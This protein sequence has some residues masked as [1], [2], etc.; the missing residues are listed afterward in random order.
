MSDYHQYR[1]SGRRYESSGGRD[2]DEIPREDSPPNSRLF[3]IGGKNVTEEE[4]REAFGKYG[5]IEWLDIKKHRETGVAKGITYVKFT[6]T[7][8][9]AAAL[10]ELNGKVLGSDP[11]PL[12]I[13]IASSRGEGGG[14]GRGAAEEDDVKGTR[15]FLVVPKTMT[16]E[17]LRDVFS[18]YGPIEHITLV[19]DK[20]TGNPRGLAYV[21][22]YRFSNAARA[23]EKGDSSYRPKFAEPKPLAHTPAALADA[24]MRSSSS[25]SGRGMSFGGSGGGGGGGSGHGMSSSY[26]YG[27]G[28]GGYS[29][30]MGGGGGG[31]MGSGGGDMMPQQQ[32][33]NMSAVFGI[34]TQ[35]NSSVPNPTGS[36]RLR[37]LFNPN[38][39]KDMFWALFNIVPGLEH[40]E[41]I[42]MTPEGAWGGVIYNNPRSAAWAVERIH[43]F[44]YPAGRKLSVNFDDMGAPCG[45]GG[46]FNMANGMPGMGGQIGST[47]GGFGDIP[48]ANKSMPSDIQSLV[49]S[50]Q[51]ATEALKQSGYGSIVGAGGGVISASS[52]G[53]GFSS[54]GFGGGG[55]VS[56]ADAQAVCSAKLPSRQPIVP[57]S[58]GTEERLFFVF[59]DAR[60]APPPGI[61]TDVFCRFGN[62]IDAYCLRGKKCGYARYAS[63]E[64]AAEALAVLNA[65]TLVG[66]RLKVVEADEEKSGKRPRLD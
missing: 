63:K 66:S 64:S 24:A 6:K 40:C 43:G 45:G 33:N 59:K 32:Q 41:L 4:Y 15:L 25:S 37:V 21:R 18:E 57:I 44:E 20:G 26:G 22:F 53:G 52:P 60:E 8:E 29:S 46:A 50:I 14:G 39:S 28:G 16:E 11:R 7:S 19:R 62:L 31:Y 56:E 58:A 5:E 38:M 3:I 48:V 34:M 9:A 55:G 1:S 10:E 65:V 2:N 42:E 35:T 54:R 13:V 51:A 61:V 36:C 23:F 47:G 12:K 49:S 30:G 17:E 27:N